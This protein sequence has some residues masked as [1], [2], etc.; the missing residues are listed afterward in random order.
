MAIVAT[1]RV[2][3]SSWLTCKKKNQK[4]DKSSMFIL[5]ESRPQYSWMHCA[6]K[7]IKWLF[8]KLLA[9]LPLFWTCGKK[10]YFSPSLHTFVILE[11]NHSRQLTLL[12]M[13][14]C[15][16]RRNTPRLWACTVLRSD[17]DFPSR[18][19]LLLLLSVI[20]VFFLPFPSPPLLSYSP[21]FI[22]TFLFSSLPPFL[23]SFLP[24][25]SYLPPLLSPLSVYLLPTSYRKNQDSM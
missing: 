21:F 18:C 24:D 7:W 15:P 13:V 5:T 12:L 11:D 20:L 3:I 10:A 16:W 2:W 23:F 4:Q 22:P 9:L 17:T 1:A 19:S 14:V 25:L 8:K 6:W